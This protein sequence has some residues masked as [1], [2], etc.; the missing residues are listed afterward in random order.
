MD[1]TLTVFYV[2]ERRRRETAD[3]GDARFETPPD[4]GTR[5]R[6]RGFPA[7]PSAAVVRNPLG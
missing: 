7:R 6:I 2:L 3:D 1:W 4:P 5:R